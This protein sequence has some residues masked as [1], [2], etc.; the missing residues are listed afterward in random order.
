MTIEAQIQGLD[1]F[2]QW[3]FTLEHPDD[4]VL[5]LLHEGELIARFSQTGATQE[6]LWEECAR[7]LVRKHGWDGCL[8][9]MKAEANHGD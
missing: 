3:G 1:V 2:P 7:H 6:S 4:H 5:L 8:W 9:T